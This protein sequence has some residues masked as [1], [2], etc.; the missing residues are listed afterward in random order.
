MVIEPATMVCL[1]CVN[2]GDIASW[3]Q[4]KFLLNNFTWKSLGNVKGKPHIVMK[5]LEC[6]YLKMGFYSRITLVKDGMQK[7]EKLLM[8]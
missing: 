3:N 2:L 1:I 5:T 8:R 4:A 6:G 7:L